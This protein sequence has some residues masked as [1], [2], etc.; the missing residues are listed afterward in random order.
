[1]ETTDE[2]LQHWAEGDTEL[3]AGNEVVFAD[4]T[5][6]AT[7]VT[8][9][10]TLVTKRTA[11]TAAVN[12]EETGRGD[13]E[14]RKEGLLARL[15]QFTDRVRGGFAGSKWVRSLPDMPSGSAGQPTIIEALDD[16]DNTWAEMNADP[17]TITPIVLAG[18]YTRAMF[19][20]DIDLLAA[21][22]TT[23]TKAGKALETARER[24]NDV[25]D[26]IY[27]ILKNYRQ[28]FPSYFVKGHALIA[29]LPRLTP[30]PGAT[31]AAVTINVVYDAATGKAKITFNASSET[32]IVYY[33]V[34]FCNGHT[35]ST[36]A[37]NVIENIP[38]GPGP[39]T[40][41]TDAGLAVAG[42]EI[43]LKVYTVNDTGNEK[44]SNAV[45]VTRP[46]DPV[47]IP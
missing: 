34:R 33:S 16:A 47:P 31:P 43:A 21:A 29:S 36:D 30:E 27:A 7:L 41:Y 23:V 5:N 45:A 15:G 10:G 9:R 20:A 8:K 26:E 44:G 32:N 1:L 24:R 22:Y 14:G 13:V 4:G 39:F 28:V 46:V 3:G 19:R 25:Q 17:A 6:R 40:Y 11:V 37:E 12:D 18:G 2:F 38:A 35:Y 42:D